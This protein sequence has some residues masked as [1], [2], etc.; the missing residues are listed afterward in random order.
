MVRWPDS[1][2]CQVHLGR[3]ALSGAAAGLKSS[4]TPTLTLPISPTLTLKPCP[5]PPYIR[6]A[7]QNLW[8]ASLCARG[9]Q[10]RKPDRMPGLPDRLPLSRVALAAL[11]AV[12]APARLE[13]YIP[14]DATPAPPR[15]VLFAPAR[16]NFM[17]AGREGTRS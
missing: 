11:S 16:A 14:A 15:M 13:F 8:R 12:S 7:N 4:L 10:T 6:Q 3:A 1:R 2:M 9:E 17:C 5:S